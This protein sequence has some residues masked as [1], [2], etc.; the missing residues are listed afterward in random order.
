MGIPGLKPVEANEKKRFET[1]FATMKP[2]PQP[3]SIQV[4]DDT[5][6]IKLS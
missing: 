2:W 1:V 3:G 4:N 5:V 6:L